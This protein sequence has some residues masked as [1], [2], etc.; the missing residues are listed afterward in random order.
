M[1]KRNK[2]SYHFILTIQLTC[3]GVK[4]LSNFFCNYSYCKIGTRVIEVRT[5]FSNV[6]SGEKT[7]HSL[8]KREKERHI[9]FSM[10]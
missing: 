4:K 8:K 6:V 9:S 3:R 7:S 1:R 2:K 5:F 10:N